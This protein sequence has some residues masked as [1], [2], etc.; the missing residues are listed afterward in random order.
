MRVGRSA[1]AGTQARVVV[2]TAD[3]AF[4]DSVRATFNASVQIDL[5]VVEGT[6]SGLDQIDVDGASVIIADLG[7][8]DD[9]E[10]AALERLMKRI[11]NWPPVVAVTKSFEGNVARRLIQMRVA[12]FLVKPVPPVEL[13]RTCARVAE[14]PANTETAEAQ[15]FTFLPAVGGAGVTTLAVQTA[16]LLL[17]SGVRG[18]TATCLVD[19]DFQHGTCADYLDIEPRLNLSEVEPRPERLDR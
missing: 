7:A 8:E 14:A 19:L 15:I 9:A 13:A 17:N 11:G 2:V 6:L 18:K 1:G 12:D 4:G 16:I 10:L 5:D 3:T